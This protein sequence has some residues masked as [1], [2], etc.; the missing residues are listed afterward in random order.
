MN[1]RPTL[2]FNGSSK[3]LYSKQIAKATQQGCVSLSIR[4]AAVDAAMAFFALT[5]STGDVDY[6]YVGL[7]AAGKLIIKSIIGGTTTSVTGGTTLVVDERVVV[8]FWSD[9]STRGI[10]LN[11]V[12]ETL[13]PSG[14]DTGAWFGDVVS[15]DYW[16]LGALKAATEALYFNGEVAHYLGYDDETTVSRRRRTYRYLKKLYG[17]GA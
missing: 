3:L 10:A 8:Q 14:T 11:G 6:C 16:S 12:A 13:T 1:S 15:P 5:D 9:G 7:T 4:P 17:I 2:E